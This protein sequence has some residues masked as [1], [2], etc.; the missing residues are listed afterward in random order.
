M[1]REHGQKVNRPWDTDPACQR[2]C[3]LCGEPII[4][5]VVPGEKHRAWAGSLGLIC[6][7]DAR[8]A[9]SGSAPK[10]KK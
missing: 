8:L 1:D 5:H 4:K 9:D 10:G 3:G 7:T 6:P 2:K